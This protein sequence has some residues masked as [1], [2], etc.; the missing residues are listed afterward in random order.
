MNTKADIT[1]SETPLMLALRIAADPGAAS[2]SD[3][4]RTTADLLD[5]FDREKD[6]PPGHNQM[7]TFLRDLADRLEA[8]SPPDA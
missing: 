2:D 5:F 4:L 6:I 8:A 7:Q 3:K 1:P